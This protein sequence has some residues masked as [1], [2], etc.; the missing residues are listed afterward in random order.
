V[1]AE[2]DVV[3]LEDPDLFPDLAGIGACDGLDCGAKHAQK[4][5]DGVHLH[6][7]EGHDGLSIS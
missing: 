6:L 3:D 5:Y 4:C 7:N 1:G 2:K